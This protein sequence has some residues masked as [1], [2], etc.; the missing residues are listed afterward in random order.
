MHAPFRDARDL[1]DDP[2]EARYRL[3][4]SNARP[5]FSDYATGDGRKGP[6]SERRT[7]ARERGRLD[8]PIDLG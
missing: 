5:E 7:R 3:A 4:G 6:W 2:F 8:D 1:G